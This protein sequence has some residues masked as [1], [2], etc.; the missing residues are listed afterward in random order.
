MARLFFLFLFKIGTKG[1]YAATVKTLLTMSA[2]DLHQDKLNNC[3][4]TAEAGRQ[5]GV[6]KGERYATLGG[7]AISNF[8]G[9]H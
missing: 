9:M 7:L 6:N 4:H 3:E 5:R 8:L 2:S 1:S